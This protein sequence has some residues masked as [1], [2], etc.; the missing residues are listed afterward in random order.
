MVLVVKKRY[1]RRCA[2]SLRL[3]CIV[4]G[5]GGLDTIRMKICP[6]LDAYIYEAGLMDLDVGC[7]FVGLAK[8]KEV[9]VGFYE[10]DVFFLWGVIGGGRWRYGGFGVSDFAAVGLE[11]VKKVCE[12]RELCGKIDAKWRIWYLDGL[13]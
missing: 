1:V 7:A 10:D 9:R 6:S 11:K 13:C 8:T 5:T 4:I 12:W 2:R 3:E